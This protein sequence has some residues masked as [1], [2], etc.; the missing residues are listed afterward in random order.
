M[1][2]SSTK[3]EIRYLQVVVVQWRQ[4]YL[5]KSVMHVWQSKC[6]AFFWPFSLTSPSSLLK[7]LWRIFI[8]TS[9]FTGWLIILLR[10]HREL[11]QRC[12]RRQRQRQKTIDF[13]ERLYMTSRRPYWCSKTMKRQ[14]NWCTKTILWELNS[15]LMQ[16]L[17]FVPMN[18]HRCWP[19]EWKRSIS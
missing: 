15:F 17:S 12:R 14:P 16:T 9:G 1:L 3:S 6:I 2:T 5:Q 11:M 18:L 8:W 13:I 19:R 10:R 7:L 4:R